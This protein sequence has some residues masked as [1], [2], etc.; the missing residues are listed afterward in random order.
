MPI[1]I[2]GQDCDNCIY[3]TVEEETKGRVKIHCDAR[4][5]RYWW[6]QNV[7]CDDKEVLRDR[8]EEL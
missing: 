6:G 1:I 3:A 2:A 4:D 7:P 5:R 8:T